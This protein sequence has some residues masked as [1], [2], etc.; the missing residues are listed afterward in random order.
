MRPSSEGAPSELRTGLRFVVGAPRLRGSTSINAAGPCQPPSEDLRVPNQLPRPASEEGMR[1]AIVTNIMAPYRVPLFN[2]L[3]SRPRVALKV[4]LAASTEPGRQWEWPDDIRFDYKVGCTAAVSLPHGRVVY[5]AANLVSDIHRLR[6][7]AVLAGGV[8]LGYPAYLGA[9]LANS[10]FYSWSE[11]TEL[12]E[13]AATPAWRWP[14]KALLARSADGCVA[15]SS[16]T[17]AYY[18]GLGVSPRRVHIALMPVDVEGI[19]AAVDTARLGR[20]RLR[21]QMGVDGVLLLH[22]GRLESYKG[23]D[24][25]LEAFLRARRLAPQL[26]LLFVGAGSMRSALEDRACKE[27]P[28]AVT[29]SGFQQPKGLAQYYACADIFCLFSRQEPYGAV[30]AEALAAGLPVVSSRAAGATVDLIVDGRNGRIID[31]LDHARCAFVLR[32]L[33]ADADLRRRMGASSRARARMCSAETAADSILAA[34][35]SGANASP[36]PHS[37]AG[38]R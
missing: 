1:L 23:V 27:A 21:R 7:T 32:D 5:L 18:Y 35:E 24:L 2:E 4:L 37:C 22:V 9:R 6:P 36:L 13:K 19:G 17:A 26:Q 15:A 11:A 30:V 38:G 29:F 33:A 16:A 3:A 34:I 20:E 12:S 28:G 25:L 14:A 10:R 31:P 8:T